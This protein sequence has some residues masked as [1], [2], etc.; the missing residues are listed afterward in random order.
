VAK[1]GN[2]FGKRRRRIGA[3]SR[4]PEVAQRSDRA[5]GEPS[6]PSAGGAH[7]EPVEAASDVVVPDETQRDGDVIAAAASDGEPAPSKSKSEPAPSKSEPAPSKSKSE[8]APSKSK[9]EPSPS[10][11]KSEPSPDLRRGSIPKNPVP[12]DLAALASAQPDEDA[13]RPEDGEFAGGFFAERAKFSSL[14]PPM[15]DDEPDA[16][17][18]RHLDADVQSRRQRNY[19]YVMFAVA[20]LAVVL[21]LGLVRRWSQT[22]PGAPPA[23]AGTSVSAVPSSSATPERV[24]PALPTPSTQRGEEAGVADAGAPDAELA[25]LDASAFATSTPLDA[26][27]DAQRMTDGG[28]TSASADAANDDLT[29]EER[30]ARAKAARGRAQA[31]L[32]RG[33]LDVAIAAGEEATS[34]DPTDGTSWLL[35]GAAYQSKGRNADAQKAFRSCTRE[36]KRGPIG[37]CQAMLR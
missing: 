20:G 8:P 27:P 26:S 12:S 2:I 10:K 11:S 25:S 31:A 24:D 36:A 9:S 30:V 6:L 15:P 19:R 17:L 34:L 28:A 32:D 22:P 16:R 14:P 1:S 13:P 7:A 33:Q 23:S 4:P 18:A 21:A 37:E 3:S 29:P 35:L 5:S